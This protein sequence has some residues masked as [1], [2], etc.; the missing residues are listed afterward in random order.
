MKVGIRVS[1][2]E[3]ALLAE[4]FHHEDLT[5]VGAGWQPAGGW[6]MGLLDR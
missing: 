6:Y 5:E 1:D 2:V 3:A 4:K